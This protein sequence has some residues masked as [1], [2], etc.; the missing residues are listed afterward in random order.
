MSLSQNRGLWGIMH[1]LA[2]QAGF[3]CLGRG[4]GGDAE[5]RVELLDRAGG[6]EAGHADEDAVGADEVIPALAD[7]GFDGDLAPAP[8]PIVFLR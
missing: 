7:A 4:F 3:H 6:A 2:V 5:M 1:S 8:L